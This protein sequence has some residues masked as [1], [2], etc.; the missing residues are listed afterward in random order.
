MLYTVDLTGDSR[1]T[2]YSAARRLLAEGADPAD[3]IET[4]RGGKLSMSGIIGKFAE[5]TVRENKNGTP[6]LQQVPYVPFAATAV[7]P[8]PAE[9]GL[10][11]TPIPEASQSAQSAPPVTRAA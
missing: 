2:V 5:L 6:S 9:T 8:R 1:T 4:Y 7:W 3:T 10:S 11:A